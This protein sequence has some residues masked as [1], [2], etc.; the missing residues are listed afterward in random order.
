MSELPENKIAIGCFD[1]SYVRLPERFYE[2]I[3]PTP[4]IAPSLLCLNETLASDLQLDL[5]ELSQESIAELFAGNALAQ[6]SEPIAQAYAGHQFGHFVP[7]LG[8]GRAVLLGEVLDKTGMR[9]DIQLKG[10]G[11]TR[12]SRSGDG[13]AALGPVIREY[14]LSEAMHHLGIPTTRSLAIVATGQDVYRETALP[15][16]VLTRVA[17]SHIRVG[18][19]QYF[20]V[21][22]DIDAVR[23][24]A[25][26]VIDRHYPEVKKSQNPYEALLISIADAQASLIAKWMHVGFIHGVMNT[27]NTAISG[28]TIDYGPCAFMDE[29]DPATV[30]SSIDHQGRYAYGNQCNIAEW[31]LTRLAESLLVFL[32]ENMDHAVEIAQEALVTFRPAFERY[33]LEGMCRKVGLRENHPEALA[34]IREFLELMKK[35]QADFTLSFRYLSRSITEGDDANR[36]RALFANSPEFDIWFERWRKQLQGEQKSAELISQ[37]MLQVNPAF[38]PRN[39]RVEQ[40]LQA[41]MMQNDFS[42][43]EQLIE[44]LSKPFEDQPANIAYMDPPKPEERVLATFCGT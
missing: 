9:R 27:D 19:F 22:E 6:G 38:I 7:Q 17:S 26:Y 2:N 41:A 23:L 25:D 16:A 21:R 43:A 44:V 20:M 3:R 4:V 5:K 29:F 18:T 33:W 32:D 34:L 13:R 30:F 37:S 39:H 42:V 1:N 24:L 8:D 15:G 40:A 11:Q 14:I 36:L 31:N 10:S 28:E 12:F 35:H